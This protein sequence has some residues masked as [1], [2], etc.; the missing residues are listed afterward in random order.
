MLPDFK[1][2]KRNANRELLRW[3]QANVPYLTPLLRGIRHFRQHEGKV[4]VILR[5]DGSKG[6]MDYP[7]SEFEFRL[8]RDEMR[9][10]NILRVQRKLLELANRLGQE[11]EMRL[12]RCVS[13]AA[14]SAGNEVSTGGELTPD[15]FLEAFRRV[16][17]DFD[18]TTG[19]LSD[20][21]VIVISPDL[22]DNLE[23]KLKGWKNDSQF[24]AEYNRILERKREEWRAREADRKLVG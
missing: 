5:M 23:P 13:E 9:T 8:D 17:L 11:Q 7:R 16:Q 24:M 4:G 15:R 14:A 2:V 19:M 21:H 1:R 10:F 20:G 6:T 3:V 22:A 12:L 18:P